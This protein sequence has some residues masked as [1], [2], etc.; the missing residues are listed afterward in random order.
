MIVYRL[1]SPSG[2][3]YIGITKHSLEVRLNQHANLWKLLKKREKKYGS[4]L[5]YAFEKY[6]P[7]SWKTEILYECD[8]YHELC[9]RE[10]E[11]IEKYDSVKN[12]YNTLI[13]GYSGWHDVGLSEEHKQKQS[14]ARKDYYESDDGKEWLKKLSER[15]KTDNFGKHRKKYVCS[16][17]TKKKISEANKGRLIGRK[18][19]PRS[20]EHCRGISEAHKGKVLSKEH[21]EKISKKQLGKKQSDYQKKVAAE[22]NSKK[23]LI[24]FP[25]GHFE[26]ISNLHAFCKKYNLTS[27]N[28]PTKSGSKGFKARKI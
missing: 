28:M 16:E 19:P 9:N 13:G 17:E 21:R 5:Y 22:A 1:L 12:G 24:T 3:S 11:F 10:M 18:F 14:K 27:Q 8:N 4:K 2:K 15:L 26:E 7:E 6:S 20:E 23:W 25:D